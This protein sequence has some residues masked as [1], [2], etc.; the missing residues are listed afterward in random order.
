M[1][2]PTKQRKR[3]P[4]MA[5][6]LLG[7]LAA[8]SGNTGFLTGIAQAE[9]PLVRITKAPLDRSGRY[10]GSGYGD[11]YH[12]C[13]GSG[14]R[15]GANLPPRSSHAMK[16]QASCRGNTYYDRFDNFNVIH[17]RDFQV[18]QRSTISVSNCDGSVG[19]DGAGDWEETAM[20]SASLPAYPSTASSKKLPSLPV[21]IT[22]PLGGSDAVAAGESSLIACLIANPPRPCEADPPEGRVKRRHFNQSGRKVSGTSRMP[23]IRIPAPVRF[24]SKQRA[25]ESLP[26]VTKQVGH[27][28]TRLPSV[29]QEPGRVAVLD[30]PSLPIHISTKPI[31]IPAPASQPAMQIAEKPSSDSWQPAA[32]HQNP[33]S[34]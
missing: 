26:A 28:P 10:W 4:I 23:P 7:S 8:V 1:N 14:F 34:R 29:F 21:N 16:Q 2:Q 9:H 27:Q 31:R 19:C 17:P 12:A 5:A 25:E 18:L 6:A 32:V 30:K 24:P 13:E 22:L 3:L 11:G 15:P 33:F 20:P